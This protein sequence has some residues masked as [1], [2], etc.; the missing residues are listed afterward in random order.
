MKAKK[1]LP[2]APEWKKVPVWV[3]SEDKVFEDTESKTMMFESADENS[4]NIQNKKISSSESSA[5][6]SRAS[7][8]TPFTPSNVTQSTTKWQLNKAETNE[9]GIK[10]PLTISFGKNKNKKDNPNRISGNNRF[11]TSIYNYPFI[12]LLLQIYFYL[13]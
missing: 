3:D 4:T 7:E 6:D 10:N 2:S 11:F 9:F 8:R 1:T 12:M 13:F 5:L